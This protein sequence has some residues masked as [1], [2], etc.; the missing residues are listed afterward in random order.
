MSVREYSSRQDMTGIRKRREATYSD[1]RCGTR[2]RRGR[3][4]CRLGPRT[5]MDGETKA[6]FRPGH[7]RL[8]RPKYRCTS[9]RRWT[10]AGSA[11]PTRPTRKTRRPTKWSTWLPNWSWLRSDSPHWSIPESLKTLMPIGKQM[12]KRK[13]CWLGGF[14]RARSRSKGPISG[15]WRAISG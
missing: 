11:G 9:S 15:S 2:P 12:R 7:H 14:R 3:V 1:R 6:R 8:R 4:C 5:L 10:K 13:R